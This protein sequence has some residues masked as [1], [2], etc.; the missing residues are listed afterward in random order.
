ML[1]VEN[2]QKIYDKTVYAVNK[3]SFEVK[4][5]EIFIM[6]G[7]NGAGKTTTIN[8]ILGFTEATAGSIYI[9]KIDAIK[10]P[11][12]VKKYVAFVDENVRLYG[13]FSGLQNRDFFSKMAGKYDMKEKDYINIMEKVGLPDDSYNRPLKNYSKGMRQKIG[14]A[15]ALAKDAPLII[16]D[17]PTSG[18]DPKAGADFVS[19]LLQLKKAKKTIFMTTHDIFRAKKLADH[20]GIMANG[21]LKIV[22]DK[23]KILKADLEKIYIKYVN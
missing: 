6:L 1:K 22:M 19:L 3:S 18:L 15:I 2:L 23:K 5:G 16:L 14:I 13:G 20:L 21:E 4:Q 11:L 17:E 8:L 7:A 10:N 12:E 9:N